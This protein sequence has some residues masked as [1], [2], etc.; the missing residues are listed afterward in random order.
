MR[1][2]GSPKFRKLPQKFF[3]LTIQMG[4]PWHNNSHFMQMIGQRLLDKDDHDHCGIFIGSPEIR[5]A[6][7]KSS[8]SLTCQKYTETYK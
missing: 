4:P 6:S 7:E 3:L 2:G 1:S 5:I 8:I